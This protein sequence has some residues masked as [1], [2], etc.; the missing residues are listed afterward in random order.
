MVSRGFVAD[1]GNP[2]LCS[3]EQDILIV[4]TD[5]QGPLFNQGG[6]IVAPP[7]IVLATISVK[8]N[9]TGETVLETVQ[10]QNSVRRVIFESRESRYVHFA[11]G[12][13]YD[14]NLTQT[15]ETVF[16]AFENGCKEY[17]VGEPGSAQSYQS[18]YVP[19][20]LCCGKD[21]IFTSQSKSEQLSPQVTVS[22]FNCKGLATAIFIAQI[23]EHVAAC[24]GVKGIEMPELVDH[25]DIKPST[26]T[27]RTF[28]VRSVTVPPRRAAQQT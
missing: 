14:T 18:P 25:P 6:L 23:I 13:F 21:W 19:E 11:G 8:S 28:P 16:R 17:P 12:Y 24:K 26:P 20:I 10:N 2:E 7:S 9:M 5:V 4:D 15:A 22:G 27:N 3:R 1:L